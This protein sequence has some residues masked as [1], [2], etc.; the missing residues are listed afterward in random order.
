MTI[1]AA[2]TG[3]NIFFDFGRA[4]NY[5]ALIFENSF[6]QAMTPKCDRRRERNATNLDKLVQ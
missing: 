4:N 1:T 6:I 5:I 2:I 3:S